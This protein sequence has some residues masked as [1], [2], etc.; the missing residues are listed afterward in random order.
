M[1][2]TTASETVLTMDL[3]AGEADSSGQQ[4]RDVLTE[5]LHHGAQQMLAAA[6]ENEVAAYIN[7]H[8]HARDSNGQRLV[9]RNDHTPTRPRKREDGCVR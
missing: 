2:R 6:I 9:V 7:A 3:S 4:A 1:D 8:A 5:I